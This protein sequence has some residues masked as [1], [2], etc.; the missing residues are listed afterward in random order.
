[1]GEE[2]NENVVNRFLK[3]HPEWVLEAEHWILPLLGVQDG[4]FVAHLRTA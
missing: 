2:E 3:E 4:G 1:M